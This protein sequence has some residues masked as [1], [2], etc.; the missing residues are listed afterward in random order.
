MR[1][2][3]LHTCERC[4]LQEALNR[5]G[6]YSEE[7]YLEL[8]HEFMALQAEHRRALDLLRVLRV[9]ATLNREPV[10]QVEESEVHF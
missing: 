9:Y 6:R 8:W 10:R 1:A 2:K 4:G 3:F 7:D 5:S